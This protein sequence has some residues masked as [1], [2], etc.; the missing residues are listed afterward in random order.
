MSK[1][2]KLAESE[3][4]A[5]QEELLELEEILVTMEMEEILELEEMA[6]IEELAELEKLAD[7]ENECQKYSFSLA[8]GY[9][10]NEKCNMDERKNFSQFFH[11]VDQRMYGKKKRRYSNWIESDTRQKSDGEPIEN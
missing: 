11:E 6:E 3:E 7:R 8:V 2:N 10:L 9:G 1:L 5:E 4:L